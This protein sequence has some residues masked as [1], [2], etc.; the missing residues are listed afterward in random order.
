MTGNPP[1]DVKSR[2]ADYSGPQKRLIHDELQR[3]LGS[4]QFANS[5]IVG[6]F[7]EYVVN[8]HLAGRG[9]KI[10]AY[11]IAT[12]ALGRSEKF[13]A[14]ND[15]I[16]RTTAGRLRKALQS[17]YD[18]C[19]KEPKV[20]ISLPKGRYVPSFEF[21]DQQPPL[22][23]TEPSWRVQA[24]RALSR[25]HILIAACAFAAIAIG[26]MLFAEWETR[27]GSL[28]STVIVDVHPV[29][30]IDQET[31]ALAKTVDLR[32]APA[33]A[34]IGLA[35]IVPPNT[36]LY[37]NGAAPV[38]DH[39]SIPFVLKASIT[40]GKA[41]RL[42][43]KLMDAGS[44]HIMWS[45]NE[46][47]S[48]K[49]IESVNIAVDR[50]AFRILGTGGAVPLA[51]ERYHGEIFTRPTCISRAQIVEAVENNS[52][53][54]EMRR[55]LER[56]VANSPNDAAAWAVLSILSTYRSTFYSAGD[57]D[58]RA[59]LV[60]HAE[61]AAER[62]TELNPIAYLTKVALMHLSLRQGRIEDFDRLQQEIRDRYPGDIFLQIR[63]ATRLARLGRGHEALEIFDKAEKEFGINLKN[64]SPGIAV[65]YFSEGEFERAHQEMLRSTSDLRFVLVLKA[66]VL[67]KLGMRKEAAPVIDRLLRTNPDIRETFY[68]WLNDIGWAKPLVREIDDGLAKAGLI[69]DSE[70]P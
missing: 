36:I 68:P 25:A 61:R 38:T 41:P 3:M 15:T 19:E 14:T 49:D 50:A 27:A 21:R 26:A 10:K 24:R 35:E 58:E 7:L 28:L 5:P 57:R 48:G 69:V 51:L 63:I 59:T 8:E 9:R 16:V 13:D 46:P 52:M 31:Q 55:C 40:D 30:Y 17:Y 56:I 54:P 53:Y 33:L 37:G 23:L 32:L 12:D 29:G 39:G 65:A 11:T 60:M 44:H 62:A 2:S 43:W 1:N 22:G 66:A 6:A 64:W 4:E 45:G 18:A 67:G 70:I 47:I 20:I 34:R 42:I